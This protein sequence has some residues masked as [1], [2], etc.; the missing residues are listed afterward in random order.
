MAD[1]ALPL[2][3]FEDRFGSPGATD[4]RVESLGGLVADRLG[5]VARVGDRLAF[6]GP[7]FV[8]EIRVAHADETGP[9]TLEIW[10]RPPADGEGGG[11]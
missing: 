1:A 6:D 4:V 10:V 11:E 9:E 8:G 5:R 7:G 3:D 2:H